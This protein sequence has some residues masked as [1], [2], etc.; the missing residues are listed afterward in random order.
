MKLKKINR[1]KT[2]VIETV[3]TKCNINANY[4]LKLN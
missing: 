2:Q 4:M 1:I 3:I